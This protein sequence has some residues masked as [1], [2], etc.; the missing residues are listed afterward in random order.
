MQFWDTSGISLFWSIWK[1]YYWDVALLIIIFSLTNFE[2]F[3]GIEFYIE[4]WN[5]YNPGVKTAIIG[6]KLDLDVER[7]VSYE[8]ASTYAEKNGSMYF[9]VSA[10]SG[11]NIDTNFT[12]M[13]SSIEED[14]NIT[15]V[16][17]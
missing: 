12:S 13:I 2:S 3:K 11:F 16:V 5:A 1:T 10:K 14:E 9:E 6:N 4:E 8:D 7:K 17:L 15:P